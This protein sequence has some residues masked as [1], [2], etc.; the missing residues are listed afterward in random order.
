MSARQQGLA[1]SGRAPANLF[2]DFRPAE[3]DFSYFCVEITGHTNVPLRGSLF[4][5]QLSCFDFPL[6]TLLVGQEVGICPGQAT[7][8]TVSCP[9]AQRYPLQ[10][11]IANEFYLSYR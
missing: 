1:V 6:D 3:A 9:G 7:V 4:S 2:L 11:R 8:L 5:S 10:M